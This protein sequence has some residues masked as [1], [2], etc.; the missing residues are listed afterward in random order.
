VT[1]EA[2][3]REQARLAAHDYAAYHARRYDYLLARALEAALPE[4]EPKVLDIG[5]SPFTERLRQRYAHVTTLGFPL[6]G[7]EH[8]GLP[9]IP[10]DLAWAADGRPIETDVRFDLVVFAEV[11]EHLTVPPEAVLPALAAVMR[12]GAALLLQTP[13]A[14]SL[15][16]RLELLFG[17]NP[18]EPLRL[19]RDNPGHFR[20]YTGAELAAALRASGFEPVA[21]AF[22]NY[23]P[24][25]PTRGLRPG[26]RLLEALERAVPTLREGQTVVARRL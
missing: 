19:S 4:A 9:H 2:H 11:L 20:E 16:K 21:H 26:R 15:F 6:G 22:E 8:M 5:P 14:A 3:A 24:R 23:F 17:R 10:F 13:N 12:P 7:T 1:D 25:P 18:Y